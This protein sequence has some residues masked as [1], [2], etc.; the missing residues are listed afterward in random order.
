[1]YSMLL[2]SISNQINDAYQKIDVEGK[3]QETDKYRLER[4]KNRG[5]AV[6][7]LLLCLQ[8]NH[9]SICCF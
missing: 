3:G 2:A 9:Y 4:G 5:I 8:Q 7:S 6:L 1:M